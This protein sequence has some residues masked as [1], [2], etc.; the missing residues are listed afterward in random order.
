MF[1]IIFKIWW[2]I[3]ILPFLLFMEGSKRFASFLKKK[4]IYHHWNILHSLIILLIIVLIVLWAN[5]FR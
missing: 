1:E 5:G 3:G 2:M 4:N